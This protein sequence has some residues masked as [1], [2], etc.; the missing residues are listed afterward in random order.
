MENRFS[1]SVASGTLSIIFELFL[2]FSFIGHISSI[3]IRT[4]TRKF[5]LAAF[6]LMYLAF[7]ELYVFAVF[8]LYHSFIESIIL[9]FF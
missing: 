1:R 2:D 6:G 7:I 9:S 3:P 8:N 5:F 4:T